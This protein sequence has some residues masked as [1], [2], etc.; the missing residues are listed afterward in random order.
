MLG[1]AAELLS[2]SASAVIVID[3][4]GPRIFAELGI[5]RRKEE[6][7]LTWVKAC[8]DDARIEVA[9]PVA[10][11][12]GFQLSS[13]FR[14]VAS[15]KIPAT[16]ADHRSFLVVFAQDEDA[17]PPGGKIA[18]LAYLADLASSFLACALTA[19][20]RGGFRH[21]DQASTLLSDAIE[22]LP[23][24]VALFDETGRFRHWNRQFAELYSGAD[25]ELV[26]GV[27]FETH[28]RACCKAGLV[29]K[30]AGRE[31]AWIAERM[32]RFGKAAGS[33]EHQLANKRW[34]RVQDRPLRRGGTIGIRTDISDLVNRELSF[35]LLFDA[36]PAPMF[37]LDRHS[38]NFLA[39]NDVAIR[40]Y[41]YDRDEFLQLSLPDIRPEREEGEIKA[42]MARLGDPQWS[43][44]LR[45]HRS[46]DGTER[47][48]KVQASFLDYEGHEGLLAAMTDVTEQQTI[49]R[50]LRQTR[51]FLTQVLDHVP[52]SV[53]VKDMWA[54]G[55]YVLYN[56]AG[57]SL[58][59]RPRE[60]ILGRTDLEIF[61]PDLGGRFR[62]EDH[63]ALQTGN[64]HQLQDETIVQPNGAARWMRTR[65]VA[66]PDGTEPRLRYVLGISDDVTESKA[67]EED[68]A[69]RA[70]HDPLTDLPNRFL[71]RERLDAMLPCLDDMDHSLAILLLDLDGFKAVND[72]RGHAVGDSLLQEAATRLRMV[73]RPTDTAA[74]L[75]GDE[76]A[77]LQFPID[78]A[79][80]SAWLAAKL[81]ASL[82]EPYRVEDHV[83]NVT[84]SI[85]IT[86]LSKGAA[87][88]G[89][90][91]KR[92]DVA[93]YR[94][95][96]EGR[97]RFCFAPDVTSVEVEG[98]ES[99]DNSL[100]TVSTQLR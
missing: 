99:I 60:D 40:F 93:L 91:M 78:Q 54:N 57:E 50:E 12:D 21:Q 72:T 65:K 38:L 19:D 55:Q 51:T 90:L 34:V 75:G 27:H 100:G 20:Q 35:R 92:A 82:G 68:I 87:D 49:E 98:D 61:G 69:H 63:L 6:A 4:F 7:L 66:L 89:S 42:M 2:V 41:G 16:D 5:D 9:V 29:P 79:G 30:A 22:A 56:R 48:V 32:D 36:N 25:V 84:V 59:G 86:L 64:V 37:I 47:V 44:Q 94:A 18:G 73:I 95:K 70:Y 17:L 80:E 11:P 83:L 26:R 8:S 88:A 97:N 28:L 31:E 13:S 74:R 45:V 10:R 15:V 46:A 24:A 77:I 81:V 33:H 62:E 71:F 3:E 76:F 52:A 1:A 43:E 96:L 39:V 85:G 14:L 67:R 53:F 58:V 23:E